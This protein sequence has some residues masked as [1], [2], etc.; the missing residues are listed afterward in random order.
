MHR[1]LLA[2][3]LIS[4]TAAAQPV[5]DTDICVLEATPGG[6]AAAIAAARLGSHVVLI[7]RTNHIGGLFAN[8]MGMSDIST[9]STVGG[10]YGEFV[11]AV[12]AY[13]AGAYGENSQQ[14]KDSSDGYRFEP[15]VAEAILEK[16]LIDAPNIT[17]F[18]M[19]QF[20][21]DAEVVNGKLV[22]ITVTDRASHALSRI[23]A[24]VFIDATYEGDLAASAHVP[25]R[26]G[27]EGREETLEP[28]AGVFYS[29]YGTKEIYPHPDTGKPDRR[30][31]AYNFRMCMTRRPD[32]RVLVAKPDGY[33]REDYASLIGDIRSGLLEKWAEFPDEPRGHSHPETTAKAFNI[34]FTPNGKTDT[35]NHHNSLVSTDLP[36]EVQPWP[37]ADWKWRDQFVQRLRT[38]TLGLLWFMQNDPDV[39]APWRQQASEWGLARDEFR[40]NGN[41]PRQP[42]VREARRILGEYDFS[43]Q[44]AI[45]LPGAPRTVIHRDS[46]AAAHYQI[47]GHAARKREPGM[48]A[49]DGFLGLGHITSPYSIPYGVIVPKSVDALLVPVAASATHLGFSTLRM[50]PCWMS[51]GQAAGVAA[52]LAIESGKQPRTVDIKRLQRV[53]LDSGQSLVYYRDLNGTERYFRAMQ[54]YGVRGLFPYWDAEPNRPV[55]RGEAIEWLEGLGIKIWDR[56]RPLETL[57]WD[58]LDNWFDRNFTRSR[59]AYVRRH[60][61]TTVLFDLGL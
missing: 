9:R 58:V 3:L 51:L 55:L 42:Y 4:F 52:H 14:V 33:R 16:M 59:V 20:D 19:R 5:I 30:I 43:A 6:I 18:K 29:F 50:E 53:L 8:G 27:R 12:R 31:Q 54:Y 38:Y 10:V 24:K 11:R 45:V 60:E 15:H 7:E 13:Y 61:F 47:D 40:D 25:Y 17:V 48:N 39:P 56:S 23:R 22:S 28:Y 26:I 44:D 49:L 34:Y 36:E 21:R 2:C 57:D 37:E 32:L 1:I 41:F 35:N 46:I